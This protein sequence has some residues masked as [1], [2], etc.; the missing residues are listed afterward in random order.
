LKSQTRLVLPDVHIPFHDPEL[1]MRWLDHARALKPD[2]VDILGDLMDCYTLSRFD[3]DP[4]R[5][6]DLSSEIDLTRTF[7][8]SLRA[9]VGPKC[10]I[11]YSE[12]NHEDRLRKAVWKRAPELADMVKSVPERLGLKDLGIKWHSAQDPYQIRDL[13][14][15]HGDILRSHAGMSARAKADQIHGSV[16]IGHTH[17]MGW[18]PRTTWSQVEHAFEVGHLSDYRQLDY[19]RTAPNWQ[20]GWVV[21]EFPTCGGFF[22]NFVHVHTTGRKRVLIYKGTEL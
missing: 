20:Q 10:D 4:T 21:V 16:I 14:Y 5:K 8:E 7:L 2:G 15:S 17:R 1:V 19:V 12:G 18:S 3:R 11:R 6:A 13:W 22:V 9:I